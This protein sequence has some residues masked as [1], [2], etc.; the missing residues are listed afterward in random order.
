MLFNHFWN[1]AHFQNA[2]RH[3]AQLYIFLI[4]MSDLKKIIKVNFMGV[5]QIK[6]KKTSQKKVFQFHSM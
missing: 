1:L 3:V 2:Q 4:F 6:Y 5:V